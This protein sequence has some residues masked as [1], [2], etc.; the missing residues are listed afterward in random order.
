MT[1]KVQ[2]AAD[3]WIIDVKDYWTIDREPGDKA[4][5]FNKERNGREEFTSLSEDNILNE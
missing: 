1:S 4:R 5:S 2:P 3:Y